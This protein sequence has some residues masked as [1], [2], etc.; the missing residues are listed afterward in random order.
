MKD[1][2]SGKNWFRW[3][4]GVG[5]G[6][7]EKGVARRC[8]GE[9]QRIA[10]RPMLSSCVSVCVCVSVCLDVCVYRVCEPQENGLR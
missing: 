5:A 7:R 2:A 10:F 1:S 6:S 3:V 9:M 8:L 4:A